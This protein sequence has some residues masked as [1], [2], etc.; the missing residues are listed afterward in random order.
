MS[1]SKLI[2]LRAAVVVTL[3]ASMPLVV[4]PPVVAQI[5]AL[6]YREDPASLPLAVRADREIHAAPPTEQV[7]VVVDG[8]DDELDRRLM[9]AQSRLERLGAYYMT[10]EA[11]G[12]D[13]RTFRFRCR[14]FRAPEGGICFIGQFEDFEA[15]S[16]DPAVAME[17]VVRAVE[18]W[19]GTAEAAQTAELPTRFR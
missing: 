7:V 15:S 17:Q 9:A 6:F 18:A 4:L 16:P 13:D 12:A 5:D 11:A 14:A 19:H 8:E 1:A 10:L 3:L 2:V